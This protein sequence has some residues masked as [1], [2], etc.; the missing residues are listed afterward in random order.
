MTNILHIIESLEF[1]GAEKVVVQLA[2]RFSESHDVAI[3]TT[4]RRGELCDS[5]NPG[6]KQFCLEAAE[7]NDYSV[8]NKLVSVIKQ[9]NIDIIHIHNWG[10]YIEAVLAA[11]RAGVMKVIHTVHG[12]YIDYADDLKSK[13]KKFIR[14][15]A[16]RFLSKYVSI[17]VPVSYSIQSYVENEIGIK[18]SKIHV[19]HNGVK[20]LNISKKKNSL[21]DKSIR[22]VMV[23]RVASIKNHKLMLDALKDLVTNNVEVFLTI[24]GDGPEF[25]N[26]KHYADENDLNKYVEFLGFRDDIESILS[27][28]DVF[29]LTS[30]YE[31]ISIALL[32]SMSMGLPTIATRVGGIPET[33]M[34]EKTGLLIQAGDKHELIDA[35]MRLLSNPILREQMGKMAYKNF[36][37]KF[38]EDNLIK[39]YSQLYNS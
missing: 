26:I 16:E 25:E 9:N 27:D 8:I 3:C 36:M 15:A 4:K 5:V 29:L 39:Q 37:E 17:F 12:P 19:I 30:N 35:I 23:G 33:V 6:V 31:G 34:H 32:E 10:V 2:N 38:N 24:A 18:P 14:H 28:K 21:S 7:G 13:L 1:G 11:K 20:G 22:L